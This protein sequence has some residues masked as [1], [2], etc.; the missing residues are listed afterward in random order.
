MAAGGDVGGSGQE[1]ITA[2]VIASW[3]GQLV[4]IAAG[5]VLPRFMDRHLGQVALGVW[6]FAWSVVGYFGLVQAGVGSSVNR[7]VAKYRSAGDTEGLQ[8]AMAS[9]NCVLLTAAGVIVVLS[10]AVSRLLPGFAARHLGEYIAEA[11][12]VVLLLGLALAIQIAF[13]V[14]SGVITGCHRWGLHN[15]INS[16]FYAASIGVMVI[17]LTRGG[18]LTTLAAV[19]CS[20]VALTEVTRLFAAHR[21]CPELRVHWRL[22]RWSV[23][24][25]MMSFGGKTFVPRV[26]ELMLNQTVSILIVAYTG[27]ASLALY[28]RPRA[29]VRHVRTLV[30]KLAFVL[31]P[32]ASAMQAT[33]DRE[34]VCK[35]LTD[36]VRYAAYLAFPMILVLIILGE[37]ILSVWMGPE[38]AVGSVIAILAVGFLA[39]VTNQPIL[40]ILT[41]LNAH[42]RPGFARLGGSICAVGFAVLALGPFGWGLPGAAAAISV[43]LTVVDGVYLPILACQRLGLPLRT[44]LLKAFSGPVGCAVPFAACL[45]FA[46][47]V[48]ADRALAALVCGMT[49]GG[50]VLM[51]AYW[52]YALPGSLRRRITGVFGGAMSR[53]AGVKPRA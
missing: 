46:R 43:P 15:G 44:Y 37:P 20:G 13:V 28:S 53:I 49:V 7:Y 52:R 16:A 17:A 26:A 45:V 10:V 3:A 11:Q 32:V 27:P 39:T 50:L 12:S 41:G 14:Y 29:L 18:G 23:A 25:R 19:Y 8:C 51:V 40:S 6:D 48:F 4:F 36:S 34:Q 2:N 30:G 22:A 47:A 38:Y 31:T 24:R 42:G 1:R 9:V 33:A 35:L 5:F 21:I